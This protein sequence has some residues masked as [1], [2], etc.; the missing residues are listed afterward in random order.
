MFAAAFEDLSNASFGLADLEAASAGAFN[1]SFNYSPSFG[2]DYGHTNAVSTQSLTFD[3][4]ID[5]CRCGTGLPHRLARA[6]AS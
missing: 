4:G 2:V 1:P 6:D 3:R 5:L